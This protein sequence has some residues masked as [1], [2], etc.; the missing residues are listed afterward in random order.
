MIASFGLYADSNKQ[1]RIAW[2]SGFLT[3]SRCNTI[4]TSLRKKQT[5][6]WKTWAPS[7]CLHHPQNRQVPLPVASSSVC[8]GI[9]WIWL[10]GS[11]QQHS[12]HLLWRSKCNNK[13]ILYLLCCLQ[14]SVVAFYDKNLLF[15][16][17]LMWYCPFLLSNVLRNVYF[18]LTW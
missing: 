16:Q 6:T 7:P 11:D 2:I 14:S 10:G 4:P 17:L 3:D 18:I 12:V 9:N 5:S 8:L 13:Y 1:T 15:I